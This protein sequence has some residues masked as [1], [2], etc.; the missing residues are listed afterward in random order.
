MAG[1]ILILW[2]ACMT[3]SKHGELMTRFEGDLSR[4]VEL[5]HDHI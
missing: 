3:T 5:S 2:M 4:A 1:N